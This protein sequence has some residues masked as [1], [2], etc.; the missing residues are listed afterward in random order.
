VTASLYLL[1]VFRYE[2]KV[3]F[4]KSE[5]P[6]LPLQT[7]MAIKHAH[8]VDKCHSYECYSPQRVYHSV[9]NHVC[10]LLIWPTRTGSSNISP[11]TAFSRTM[12]RAFYSFRT[13]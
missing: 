3:K 10:A 2:S 5:K 12:L 4:C 6:N 7:R 11:S 13:W 8:N 1:L 9:G